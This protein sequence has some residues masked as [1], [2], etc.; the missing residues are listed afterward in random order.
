MGKKERSSAAT[1]SGVFPARKTLEHI[2]LAAKAD[3]MGNLGQTN[4]VTATITSNNKLQ[5]NLL[6]NLFIS[7]PLNEALKDIKK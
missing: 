3:I 7:Y 6:I 4:Q 5:V 1:R 2:P